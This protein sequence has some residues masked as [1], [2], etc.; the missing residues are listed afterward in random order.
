MLAAAPIARCW[1]AVH[2]EPEGQAEPMAASVALSHRL[3]A[4]MTSSRGPVMVAAVARAAWA[5]QA[6]KRQVWAR[7]WMAVGMPAWAARKN[8][9]EQYA[10]AEKSI[11]SVSAVAPKAATRAAHLAHQRERKGRSSDWFSLTEM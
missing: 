5:V 6:C 10:P 3:A 7:T 2:L 8:Q 4:R 9:G 1:Q 11:R